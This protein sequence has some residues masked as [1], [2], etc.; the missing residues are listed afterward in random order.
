M[1]NDIVSSKLYDKRSDFFNILIVRFSNHGRDVPMV[2][3][4]YIPLGT[5]QNRTE[6]KFY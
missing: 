4:V 6:Q 5:E 1:T 3:M 2:Y